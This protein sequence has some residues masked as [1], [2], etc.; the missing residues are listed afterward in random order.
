MSTIRRPASCRPHYSPI[1]YA[2]SEAS[3]G[4]TAATPKLTLS[5][6]KTAFT[7][8]L[9][10]GYE[11]AR[12]NTAMREEFLR[13]S[14]AFGRMP[15]EDKAALIA[16]YAKECLSRAQAHI[17]EATH[18]QEHLLA[19]TIWERMLDHRTAS[20]DQRS[21]FDLIGAL[22]PVLA[23]KKE[24]IARE[25]GAAYVFWANFCAC[26]EYG[27]IGTTGAQFSVLLQL[28]AADPAAIDTAS[29]M[30]SLGN[31]LRSYANYLYMTG[32]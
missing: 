9:H 24:E 15:I 8:V 22:F 29:G 14:T 25:F 11:V 32:D 31:N 13:V 10:A 4:G 1:C 16:E 27:V 3:N 26:S 21:D 19:T 17:D 18:G 7:T 5:E 2:A 30:R 12:H 28:S 20:K 23:L 6:I